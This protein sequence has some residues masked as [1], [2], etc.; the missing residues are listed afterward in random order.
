MFVTKRIAVLVWPALAAVV[1]S[2]S[3][4]CA[5]QVVYR[6][7]DLG[8]LAGAGSY[9]TGINEAGVTSGWLIDTRRRA[10]RPL[11]QRSLRARAG[12]GES[13]CRR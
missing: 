13:D 7:V 11:D 2:A 3:S 1:L 10:C 8:Q 5:Q 12:S 9:A 6:L 4:V